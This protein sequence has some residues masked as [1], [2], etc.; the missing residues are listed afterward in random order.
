MPG[1]AEIAWGRR[2]SPVVRCWVSLP[3]ISRARTSA[4]LIK[5]DMELLE[6][7]PAEQVERRA[8]LQRVIDIRIDDLIDGRRTRTGLC[9]N[10]AVLPRQLARHRGV[11]LRADVHHHVVER[12]P[13]P[14]NWLVMF[15]AMIVRRSSRRVR[16]SGHLAGDPVVDPRRKRRV[17]SG[18]C[19][20]VRESC[21]GSRRPSRS[22]SVKLLAPVDFV[23]TGGMTARRTVR[24]GERRRRPSWPPSAAGGGLVVGRVV[25]HREAVRGGIELDGVLDAGRGERLVQRLGLLGGERLRRSRRRRRRP[26]RASC[27]PAGAGCRHRRRPG[28]RRGTTWPPRRARAPGRRPPARCARP[29]SSRWCRTSRR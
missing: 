8:E 2:R 21:A 22:N 28:R 10:R 15:V 24:P 7:L 9:S 29:C 26:P 18:R 14:A 1:F 16:R 19:P 27:R 11:R 13:Q 25:G 4:A 3:G 12:Q 20:T 5:Q 23:L 6:R 17:S